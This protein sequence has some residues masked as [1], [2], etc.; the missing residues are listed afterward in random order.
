MCRHWQSFSKTW[1][2][3]RE[4]R[5]MSEPLC[6]WGIL[7]TANIARKNWKAIGNAG[8]SVLTAVASRDR[9]RA[10]RFIEDCQASAPLTPVPA[11]CGSYQELLARSDVDAVYIPLPTGVRKEWVIRAARAGK[12]VLCEKPC[13]VSSADVRAMLDACG[14]NRVQFM[15][16][17]MFMHSQRMPLL[18]QALGGTVLRITSQF[19]FKASGDFL[20]ANIRAS[21]TLEPL[22]CLGDLGWYNVRFSLWAMNEELPDRV[23]GHMLAQHAGDSG[24]PVPMEF[25]GELFFPS[26]A[27]ASFYCSFRAENQQWAVISGTE[28]YALVPDFVLP[29][30]GSEVEFEVNSPAFRVQGC[31]FNMES[32]PRRFAVHEYSNSAANSQETNMIRTFARIVLSGQLE[33]AWAEQALATQQ[34]LDACLCSALEN[35]K[36][37]PVLP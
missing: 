33:P 30:Y 36:T 16:G 14:E 20:T 15:D 21:N 23:T 5:E 6:R 28:G 34:V 32:H 29:F 2:T 24:R 10:R 22:G 11:A 26:G 7:G 19:S 13:G 17:V 25:S 37:L 8:N 35:G 9:E 18:R 31:D 27:S 1:H 4:N 3:G 12:H